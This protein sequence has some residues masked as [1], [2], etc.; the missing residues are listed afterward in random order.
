[1]YLRRLELHGF[2]TFA[3]RTEL[4][5]TPGITAIVG[6]NGS[7]KSNVFDA[8]RW[9]LGEM[10]FRSLRSGRMDD[11]IFAGS[12]AKRGMGQAEVSLT[13]NNDSG[14][15]PVEF[16]E[17]TVMRR[18]NRGGE[19]ECFLNDTP[20]RLRDIQ[21]LFLGTGLGG[22]SYSLIGQGQVDSVLNAG[23]EERRVLLEEAAGLARYKRRR[24]EAERRLQH[25]A[26]NL[27]R[28]QDV[29][30]EL[31]SQLELLR[32]QAEA[33]RAY[34]AYTTEIRHLE[35]ALQVEEARRITANLK[36]LATQTESAQQQLH[37]TATTASEVG[38][39]I[40]RGRARAAEVATAWEQAQRALLQV[41]EDLAG[42][43]SVIQVLQ[44]R[45]RATSVQR[46]RVAADVQRLETR[47]AQIEEEL[48]SLRD[49]ADALSNRRDELL[50]QFR[51]AEEA[52]LGAMGS[53]QAASERL[54][55]IR[56]ELGDLT[57]ARSR[58][59]HDLTRM[60]AR[61]AALDEQLA[62]FQAKDE[63]LAAAAEHLRSRTAELET[64][65]AGLMRDLNAA[66][67][68]LDDSRGRRSQIDARVGAIDEESRQ[69]GADRQVVA[70]TLSFL[71]DL[72]TQL[73][74]YEQGV[75][76][77]LLAKRAHP[78]RF[79]G[80]RYPVV[81]LLKVAPAYRAAIE[82]A[83]GRRLFSL[84]ASTL[85]DVKG[86]VAYLRGNGQGSATFLPVDLM[87]SRSRLPLPQ[88]S[89]IVG[90]ATDLVQLANGAKDVIDALLGDVVVV[91]SLDAAAALRRRGYP[92]R[93]VTLDGELLSPDGVVSVRG[94]SDRDGVILGRAEQIADLRAR[95]AALETHA[96]ELAARRAQCEAQAR[97]LNEA[98]VDAE[99]GTPRLRQAVTEHQ[100]AL[101]VAQAEAARLP[102][103]RQ[104]VDVA[105]TQ[106]IAERTRLE[107]ESRRLREDETALTQVIAE[108]EQTMAELEAGL[109]AAQEASQVASTQLADVRVELAEVAATL[110]ALQA[111]IESSVNEGAELGARCNQLQGEIAVLDG[112]R[113][114]LDHSLEE[115]Q[116]ARTALVAFQEATRNQL[117]ALEAERSAL[118]QSL[119][120]FEANW[121]QIQE[122]LREIEDQ[123]HRLEVRHAQVEA[124]LSA[125][126]RRISEEFGA[127]WTDVRE[128]RLPASRD[129]ALGRIEALRGLLAALGP[130]NLRAIDEHRA[131]AARVESLR[132]HAEDLERARA[133]LNALIQRLDE[134]LRVKFAETFAA[135]NE[136]F[137]RLFVRLFAGGRARLLLA[138]PEPAPSALLRA[139]PSTEPRAATEP[140]I[141]IEAQLPGKKMRSLSALSGG[142]RVLV[143]LSLIFAMLRVHPSPFCIFDE[144]EAALDDVNTKK[145]TT[146]LRELAERTQVLIITHN[147]GTM[148][149]A[150][151]LYGVTM[152]V[153]GVSKVISMRLT[154]K[155][156]L[157]PSAVT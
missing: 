49:H 74:G 146:L 85:E 26:T 128:V 116:Q 75:R 145:F 89:E 12:T 115:A 139:G 137:N 78:E 141:E 107:A 144:V 9:A 111:R 3:D 51:V 70:S 53:S 155:D 157:E 134:V 130:V 100:T 39:K 98:I 126:Q 32:E 60:D 34:Q 58:T 41:V 109:R 64:L 110:E 133:A 47:L 132:A 59:L 152:E 92:G 69:L 31:S 123:A 127:N 86:S 15:L 40:D 113:H 125:A 66:G 118:Q 149:A 150:D 138:E 121:R 142:E 63:T 55:A 57:A 95:L 17:V 76:E 18:A 65:L 6:P 14:V 50:D 97:V 28:V 103:Q 35:L 72:H 148:E 44:E 20:C 36:R 16:T 43:E 87:T 81:E 8:I 79:A 22:R 114:L 154:R 24:R 93:I 91:A 7:G 88:D 11:I 124:E 99:A 94:K 37:A 5:F 151:V 52:Q 1:M 2:K 153:V 90:R 117:A 84:V 129:E 54:S 30:A 48:A 131:V 33:A 135:V 77:I 68:R 147:K 21:M 46:E 82:A 23:P 62:A 112:E 10:S 56:D 105:R 143:A 42:R 108:R 156:A 71:E 4:E 29:L 140:G 67:V 106:L 83:L 122:S 25:A 19:G 119:M 27:L 101:T 61:M 136:E 96:G 13:I 38:Q 120:Q 104:E 80:I 45:V 102:A 73:A